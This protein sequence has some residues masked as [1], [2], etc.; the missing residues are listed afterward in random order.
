MSAIKGLL[1][2]TD[3]NTLLL[4]NKSIKC[5]LLDRLMPLLTQMGSAVFTIFSCL[6]I[7]CIGKGEVRGVGL[8]ALVSLTISHLI[9][10]L[11]KN[12]V[13]RLRPI[14]VLPNLN[15]FNVAID[16]YS[17]PSGHTTAVFAIA[18]ILAFNESFLAL[19]CFPVA[20]V[21]G[22]TR[23]Y[24]G[25]HYPSDVLAGMVLATFTSAVIQFL[26]NFL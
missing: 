20:L 15:T 6:L 14:E 11:L 3:L 26:S 8:K 9:V 18:T 13:C 23:L 24:L 22:I 21:V 7:I 5:R 4:F 1:Y 12:R 10:N 19:V 16:Y 17:F 25:V 2:T